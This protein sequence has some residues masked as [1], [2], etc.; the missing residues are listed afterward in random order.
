MTLSPEL[1]QIVAG[2]P[3]AASLAAVATA[4]SLWMGRRR[5][6]LNEA[7][8]ELRRPLQALALVSPG[9]P[10]A[11]PEGLDLSVEMATT[12][13]ERL[14]REINGAPAA[15][16]TEALSARPLLEAAVGR[17]RG[18]AV[19]AG[20]SLELGPRAADA[21]LGGDRCEIAQALDNL[22]VNAIDH[23]GPRIR[24]GA[25]LA[26]GRLRI[27]VVDSGRRSR[28]ESRRESPAE[29]IARLSGRRRHG[30]GLRIVRRTAAAHG[31][32]FRLRCSETG[33]EA[34]LELPLLSGERA[35]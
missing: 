33:T 5:M 4:R 27:A 6:A 21:V 28:P 22:I 3:F 15:T 18:R 2:W 12:A 23:G 31:G 20:G 25:T 14:D 26:H 34:V 24:V 29:L 13:L 11:L 9:T 32:D 17:W 30:H 8:H 7:L 19:L 35:A 10:A 16:V 1:S